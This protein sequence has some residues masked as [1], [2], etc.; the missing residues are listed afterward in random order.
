MQRGSTKLGEK[1]AWAWIPMRETN[2][3]TQI[4]AMGFWRRGWCLCL[5]LTQWE[6]S[7][8]AAGTA[9]RLDLCTPLHKGK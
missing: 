8:A 3:T 9:Q 5:S 2:Q 1:R 4:E 7:T 6:A